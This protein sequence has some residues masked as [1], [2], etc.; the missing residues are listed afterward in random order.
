MFFLSK[1]LPLFLMPLGSFFIGFLIA[2]NKK[3]FSILYLLI[4]YLYFFSNGII[5]Q[6]LWKYIES[7]WERKSFEEINN[8]EAIVVLGGGR[9]SIL[10]KDIIYEWRDPDRFLAGINLFKAGKANILIFTGGKNHYNNSLP[11]E[12]VVNKSNAI[13]LGIPSKSIIVTSDV[14]NTYEEASEIRRL[15]KEKLKNQ[16]II[17]VTSAFH[18]SRAITLFEKEGLNIT[19]F[20]VDF[21][22]QDLSINQ[23]IGNPYS[24][25]PNAKSLSMSSKAIR[26]IIGRYSLIFLNK[27]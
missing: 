20:P 1:F 5:S 27:S 15:S 9:E 13:E 14:N 21:K 2:L 22:S 7:P 17:L 11:N 4:G 8:A 3:K 24:L 19:P 10:H 16:S 6:V 18:M 12:G 23:I 26:E 25:I